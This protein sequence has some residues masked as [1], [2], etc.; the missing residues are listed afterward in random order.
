MIKPADDISG[1]AERPASVIFPNFS[2][3]RQ[4][5]LFS[6]DHKLPVLRGDSFCAVIP[7]SS[8]FVVLSI[9][10][11]H[12]ASSTASIY[13]NVLFPFGLPRFTTTQ[14]SFSVLR[15]CSSHCLNSSRFLAFNKLTGSISIS[16]LLSTSLRKYCICSSCGYHT[17]KFK[18]AYNGI[19]RRHNAEHM[20]KKRANVTR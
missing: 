6:S 4:R 13:Q 19:T 5:S 17:S 20:R 3:L 15:F 18:S 10:P 1:K 2:I 9:Q 12:I 11:K 7:L 16:P 8:F 14:H